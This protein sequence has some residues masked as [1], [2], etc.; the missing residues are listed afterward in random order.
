ME[1]ATVEYTRQDNNLTFSLNKKKIFFS[2]PRQRNVTLP[3]GRREQLALT[4]RCVDK[5]GR[6][7]RAA[8]VAMATEHA[9]L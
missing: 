3:E 4:G 1:A 5:L 6:A 8:P 9:S 2:P 7:A